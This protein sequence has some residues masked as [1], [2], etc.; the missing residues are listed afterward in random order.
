MGVPWLFIVFLLFYGGVYWFTIRWEEDKLA[1]KFPDGW[2]EYL[3]SVP[4]FIPIGR[5]PRYRPGE[6]SWAQVKRYKEMQN[7]SVVLVIYL[8]LWAKAL[9]AA[10]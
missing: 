9:L 1:E 8:I 6:F 3:Q 4:R 10:G 2:P 7:A 5:L